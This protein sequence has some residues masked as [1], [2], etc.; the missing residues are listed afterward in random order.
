MEARFERERQAHDEIAR[1][2]DPTALGPP[3]LGPADRWMLEN[4]GISPGVRVLDLGCGQGD[5]TIYAIER[6][7]E[8]T[9][10]D[11]SPGMVSVTEQRVRATHPGARPVFVV[12]P[13]ELARLP[14]GA[15][16]LVIGR[17]I[18]HHLDVPRAAAG[19]AQVLR[20]GGKA[21]F[22]ENSGRNG[23]LIFARDHIAGRFGVPR[24]G[25]EDEHPLLADDISELERHFGTVELD[26]PSFDFFTILD[27]QVFRYKVPLVSRML[28][29]LDQLAHR[30]PALRKYSYRVVVTLRSPTRRADT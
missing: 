7:A 5:L 17:F 25:T 10:I 14:A 20:G 30:V 29:A 12:A 24:L 15:Y 13:F 3:Q 18:L 19:L 6:G 16:D 28:A 1:D 23:L 26:H 4:S 9:A 8:V 2:I 11:V 27:R 22:L 21:V